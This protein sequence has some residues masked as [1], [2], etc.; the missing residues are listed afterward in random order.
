[1][2]TFLLLC[3]RMALPERAS[4]VSQF[5]EPVFSL[6]WHSHPLQILSLF[7]NCDKILRSCNWYVWTETFLSFSPFLPIF[8]SW[9]LFS[10]W[11][12]K[13]K[14]LDF[15]W[16]LFY[17]CTY[18]ILLETWIYFSVMTV[19]LKTAKSSEWSLKQ[20]QKRMV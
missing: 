12:P 14:N 15:S 7:K 5:K 16:G 17:K 4:L 20:Q 19:V 10:L 2:N 1:M 6:P 3:L 18:D 9:L 11:L 13:D 8:P